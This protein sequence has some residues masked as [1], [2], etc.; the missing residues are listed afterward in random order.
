MKKSIMLILTIGILSSIQAYDRFNGNNKPQHKVHSKV[1]YD[2][3]HTS[4]Q[5]SIKRE[6][7]KNQNTIVKLQDRVMHLRQQNRK[8]NTFLNYRPRRDN[9]LSFNLIL[10]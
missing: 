6:R 5:N 7:I 4:K 8:H 3:H 2:K 10:R 1:H 9:M